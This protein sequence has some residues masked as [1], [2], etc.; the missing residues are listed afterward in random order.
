MITQYFI[1][2]CVYVCI[3]VNGSCFEEQSMP[4]CVWAATLKCTG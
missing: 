2:M 3:C 4:P 1:Y